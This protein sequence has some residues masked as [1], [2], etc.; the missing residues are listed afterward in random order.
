M[1]AEREASISAASET[2]GL[3]QRVLD[4]EQALNH[5]R[6]EYQA[7]KTSERRLQSFTD[8]INDYAFISLDSETRIVGWSRG[9]EHILGYP[10]AEVLGQ[11]GNVIFT[12][13]DRSCGEDENELAIARREGCA[14]D[15][16]WHIRRDGTRFWGSGIVTAHRDSFGKI[17]GYSKIMRDLTARRLD[18]ERLRDAE[19]RFRLFSDNVRDYALVPVDTEGNISGW[20]S[21]AERIFGYKEQEILGRPVRLFFT[22]EDRERGESEKDLTRALEFGRA[23]DDRWMV[24]RDG[25]RFWARWVTTPMFD[26]SGNLRGFAKVLRDE[27]ERK[28]ADDLVKTS[29]REKELLLREIH[30]RIKNNLHVISSLLSLQ[31]GHVQDA[32]VQRMFDELQDRVRSIAALHE[33]LYG[34]RDLANIEFGP[35]MQQL[36]H[37]LVELYA[38]QGRLRVSVESDDV[39]LSIEQALPLG[40]IVNE[41]VSNALKHAFPSERR[42]TVTVRFRYLAQ[43]I[44]EEHTLDHTWCE[45][46]VQDDGVGIRNPDELWLGKSMGMR[47]VDLLTTQLHGR[48]TVDRSVG[49]RFTVQFPV[50]DFQYAA[51]GIADEN[52]KADGQSPA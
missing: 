26:E 25:S 43:R 16:R 6:E 37:E 21:G 7:A 18:Q 27:T 5:C 12:P 20:N 10:A 50:E 28:Q 39:V 13:E 36:V 48:I 49:T 9:A 17:E 1:Q 8:R 46:S 51:V 3:R 42:G 40:L 47:I 45:L 11:P 35:Y 38:D 4:L 33:S 14:E 52:R 23:E 22:P 32:E 15:E 34:S 41:L 2:P 24:R 29:L 19:E 30:H 44:P 31:S